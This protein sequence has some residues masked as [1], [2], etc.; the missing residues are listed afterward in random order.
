MKEYYISIGNNQYKVKFAT[1]EEDKQKGLQGIESLPEDEG[2]LFDFRNS[3]TSPSMWMKDTKIPLEIIFL[4]DTLEVI[5]IAKGRPNSEHLITVPD[6]IYVLEVNP[7]SGIQLGDELEFDK[8]LM[9]VLDS[10]GNTQMKLKGGERVFSRIFTKRLI[11]WVKR[12]EE[13]NKESD[14]Y[15]KI[16]T[17]IGKAMFK[18][19]NAQDTRPNEY[20]E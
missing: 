19:I 6:A 5:H 8:P 11:K 9:E 3:K 14:A 20:V 18:E 10:D 2:M 15:K 12:A 17:R 1:S 4:D 13:F 7:K 16:S